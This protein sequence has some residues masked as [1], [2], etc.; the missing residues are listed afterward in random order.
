MTASKTGTFGFLLSP[1][2]AHKH[3][4]KLEKAIENFFLTE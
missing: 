2:K 1:M 3:Y 4:V